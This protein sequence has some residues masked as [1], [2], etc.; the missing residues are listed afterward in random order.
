MKRHIVAKVAAHPSCATT[1]SHR[2]PQRQSPVCVRSTSKNGK[3]ASVEDSSRSR[4]ARSCSRRASDL[5]VMTTRK[6][7]FSS[8][9]GVATHASSGR[10]RMPETQ[11]KQWLTLKGC[12]SLLRRLP[13]Q[14]NSRL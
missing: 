12:L 9:K 6:G 8:M 4:Y 5:V 10:S 3:S 11:H 14:A 7:S 2:I 13:H 1:A